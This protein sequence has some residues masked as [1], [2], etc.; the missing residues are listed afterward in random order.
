MARHGA[1]QNIQSPRVKANDLKPK[2]RSAEECAEDIVDALWDGKYIE[3]NLAYAEEAEI[4][5]K[6]ELVL[7]HA[8]YVQN[9]LVSFG[10][11]K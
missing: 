5:I 8:E 4:I 7:W 6:R 1:N 11:K 9:L 3:H 10:V 2:V